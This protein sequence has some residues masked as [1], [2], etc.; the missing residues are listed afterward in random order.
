[1]VTS[2]LTTGT[3]A[4]ATNGPDGPLPLVTAR[5]VSRRYPGVL[6]L[7][8]LDL[9]LYAG[10][11]VALC[12]A[13]GAGKSTF[14]RLL[15]GQEQ[16]SSGEIRVDGVDKP[17]GSQRDAF[18]AGV[19][20][21]H[22]EPLVVDD[23]TVGENVWLYDLRRR[24]APALSHFDT[25]RGRATRDA[26][27]RVG[28]KGV[29]TSRRGRML[30]PGQ[31]QMLA[32]SRAVVYPHR[33]LIL[34][35]TT[36]STTEAYFELV[37][38][39]VQREREQGT[40]VLFVSHRMQEVFE[41]ADRIAVLRN[42]RLVTV[43]DAAQ[44]DAEEVTLH[45]IGDAIKALHRP[46][47]SAHREEGPHLRVEG[48][49]VGS[50]R[51][52]SFDVG[53]GEILGIYG[54]VGSGRSSVGRAITGQIKADSGTVTIG[55][56]RPNLRSP[57]T[58]LRERIAYVSEDRR[59]EGFVQDFDNGVNLTLCSLRD[60]APGGVLQQRR[61]RQRA[62]ELVERF[63]VKGTVTTP[64]RS[65]SG[66]NQQKVC[67]AKWVASDPDVIVFDEPTKGIDVG[68]RANIYQIIYDLAEAGKTV[69]VISSEA[70]EVLLLSH[71]VLVM[72]TGRVVAELDAGHASTEEI[73]RP[74]LGADA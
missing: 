60:F 52:V 71:R 59:K 42:G 43:L 19:L 8:D 16:P 33:V 68:A 30:P 54:L 9:D 51:D 63:Q 10:E 29:P 70:E 40:C 27:D 58:A 26:L 36:A 25:A 21:L 48:L 61:L 39:L 5:G 15:S 64:T 67:V 7:D 4:G 2:D 28:L 38:E 72:R 20:M 53:R 37:K 56:R 22:Q 41:I 50:A 31:R 55:G 35:E 69:V 1:V 24:G 11:V 47:E 44:T 6:A 17:I 74:A 18:D 57:R 46:P 45:M 65:L 49:S 62:T 12:G 14:A 3:V 23:F 13:N 73:V 34:D 66:G 32:L